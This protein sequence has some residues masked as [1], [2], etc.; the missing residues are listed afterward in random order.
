MG[1]VESRDRASRRV[2]SKN[3]Y[4]AENR[5]GREEIPPLFHFALIAACDEA[6]REARRRI[7]DEGASDGTVTDMGSLLLL[8]FSDTD[9][10][11]HELVWVKP[12]VP[13]AH[14]LRRAEWTR[15]DLD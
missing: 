7:V 10:G 15:A 9:E 8:S 14:G 3:T 4:I 1:R 2:V 6:F 12:G 5:K 13:V 11:R